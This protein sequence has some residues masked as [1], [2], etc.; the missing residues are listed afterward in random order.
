MS[1]LSLISINENNVA[2]VET[3]CGRII[4]I[5]NSFKIIDEEGLVYD[6][7]TV[8]DLLEYTEIQQ[9]YEKEANVIE[10]TESNGESGSLFIYADRLEYVDNNHS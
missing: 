5:V 10:F 8:M 9:D 3:E 2:W 7:C 1:T 4:G 6:D